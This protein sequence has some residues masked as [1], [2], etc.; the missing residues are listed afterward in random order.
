MTFQYGVRWPAIDLASDGAKAVLDERDRQLEDRIGELAG[1]TSA[2]SLGAQG[3]RVSVTST[4]HSM[5][6]ASYVA[7]PGLSITASLTPGRIYRASTVVHFAG[8]ASWVGYRLGLFAAGQQLQQA[9]GLQPGYSTDQTATLLHVWAPTSSATTVFDVRCQ[10]TY[11]TGFQLY[12]S[13]S[14]IAPM[15]FVV[16]DIGPS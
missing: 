10:I 9:A 3:R 11:N 2:V 12:F 7:I 8:N 14:A 16:E 6:G 5:T 1:S 13:A 15:Q 4:S